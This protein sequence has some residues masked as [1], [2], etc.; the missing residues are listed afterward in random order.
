MSARALVINIDGLHSETGTIHVSLDRKGQ[1][2]IR[3]FAVR[4]R[5]RMIAV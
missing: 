4:Y 5:S 1:D 2:P 3:D